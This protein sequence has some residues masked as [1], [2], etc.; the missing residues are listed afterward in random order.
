MTRDQQW[1][2]N[3][4]AKKL[5]TTYLPETKKKRNNIPIRKMKLEKYISSFGCLLATQSNFCRGGPRYLTTQSVRKRFSFCEASQEYWNRGIT[6]TLGMLC[7]EDTSCVAFVRVLKWNCDEKWF[8]ATYYS[9]L[10]GNKAPL[11]KM[12]IVDRK[13]EK[14]R[15]SQKSHL[16]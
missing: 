10:L 6:S 8:G 14:N 5:C 15:L 13:K 11:P 1:E 3:F 4:N 12:A 16:F 2:Q 9:S 7:Y